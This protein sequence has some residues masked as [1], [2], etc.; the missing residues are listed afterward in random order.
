LN[1]II[2]QQGAPASPKNTFLK[3]FFRAVFPVPFPI[4]I[5]TPEH[6]K[7]LIKRRYFAKYGYIHL[8]KN[9]T[10]FFVLKM[11]TD[12][13]T[14]QLKAFIPFNFGNTVKWVVLG[15][16]FVDRYF[17]SF[18]GFFGLHDVPVALLLDIWYVL[19]SFW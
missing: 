8:L 15:R 16:V 10:P 11:L 5:L 4:F 12:P 2:Q 7:N 19:R 1:F 18:L 17:N 13:R 14:L 9:S 6:S 3:G